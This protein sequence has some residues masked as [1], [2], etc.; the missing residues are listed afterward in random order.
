MVRIILMNV[1]SDDVMKKQWA[2]FQ[3][4][5]FF[6]GELTWD[7]VNRVVDPD[8]LCFGHKKITREKPEFVRESCIR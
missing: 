4:E 7:D 8:I 2:N 5:S 3:K 6:V 1:E